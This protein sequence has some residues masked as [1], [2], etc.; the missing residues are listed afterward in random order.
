MWTKRNYIADCCWN[1]LTLGKS[2]DIISTIKYRITVNY[3]IYIRRYKV[4]KPMISV[5][6]PVYN[7]EKYIL[8]TVNSILKQTYTDF[9]FI[10]ID[11]AST[12]NSVKLISQ[13]ADKRIKLYINDI[14]NY[15]R[16]QLLI[17]AKVN[18][19]SDKGGDALF[20]LL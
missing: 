15:E 14:L 10:I 13:I 17:G 5:L 18:L 19:H 9:E 7:S 12:D 11:D 1:V 8:H 2:D 4:N 3:L 16:T 20:F 6:M